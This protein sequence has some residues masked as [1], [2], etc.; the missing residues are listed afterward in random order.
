MKYITVKNRKTK[1]GSPIK[2]YTVR[3]LELGDTPSDDRDRLMLAFMD[4]KKNHGY[5]THFGKLCCGSCV[6][7]ALGQT[8]TYKKMEAAGDIRSVFFNIQGNPWTANVSGKGWGR[9]AEWATKPGDCMFISW[10]G[11]ATL[12]IDTIQ[13]YGLAC[14]WDG[15][16]YHSICVY[17]S[18][19]SWMNGFRKVYAYTDEEA[20]EKSKEIGKEVFKIGSR[21]YK[22]VDA[23]VPAPYG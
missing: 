11:D 17:P 6:S 2:P 1:Y 16:T 10:E 15:N 21:Y 13:K 23:P 22:R 5:L 20:A 8:A 3:K 12:I 19:E 4:L 18:A 9:T 7:A 14:E